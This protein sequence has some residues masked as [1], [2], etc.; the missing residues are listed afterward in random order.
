MLGVV[1]AAA[2]A[3]LP[4]PALDP[5]HLAVPS[6]GFVT[7]AAGGVVL[8]DLRGR[9][10]GHLDRFRLDEV[11]Q[12]IRRP[13]EVL[14]R[15]GHGSY[16]LGQ[17]GVRRV[18]PLRGGWP[19]TR[20]GCHPAPLPFVICG[21]PY[22]LLT[23]PSTVYLGGR[24]VLGPL[25]SRY[26]RPAGYWV[27][28]QLSP[29]RRTLLLQ[30]SGECEIPTAYLARADGTGLHPA[31]GSRGTESLALGW[32]RSGR[33]VLDLP[34]GACGATFRRPGIYLLDPRSRCGSFVYRGH[35]RLWGSAFA[36]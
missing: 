6:Q 21:Y 31:V 27:G 7:R 24:K 1:V 15:K 2:V 22:S 34:R 3:A 36:R 26:R 28:A 9:A 25:P 32:T 5:A 29:D 11:A 10:L 8:V 35:G 17:R 4:G 14:L 33:A 13:R 12:P 19:R 30:W 23:R 16:A 20:T 18:L